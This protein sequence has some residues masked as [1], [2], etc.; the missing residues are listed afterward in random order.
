MAVSISRRKTKEKETKC[1][2]DL[3][4]VCVRCAFHPRAFIT[5]LSKY[6]SQMCWYF[7]WFKISGE[8]YPHINKEE[9]VHGYYHR[10]H[11]CV[12]L[13]ISHSDLLVAQI[14]N[15]W[16]YMFVNTLSDCGKYLYFWC[17][18]IQV[19]ILQ[20]G[21]EQTYSLL[22]RVL[23]WQLRYNSPKIQHLLNFSHVLF[24]WQNKVSYHKPG[25]SYSMV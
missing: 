23:V 15:V 25:K 10:F 21:S 1:C 18:H 16:V 19:I 24:G 8:S 11:S 6:F 12:C 3:L 7:R 2:F 14:G 13:H 22:L 17:H 5:W 9:E 20:L 4:V